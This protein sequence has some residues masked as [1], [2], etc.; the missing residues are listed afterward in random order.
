MD[1]EVEA[2]ASVV[3]A[4]SPVAPPAP[5]PV[6]P[7]QMVAR[8]LSAH[9]DWK[10]RLAAAIETGACETSVEHAA[11][12][13]RC[14]FGQWLHHDVP[15]RL[16]KTWDYATV[17]KRHA[18]LH[19]QVAQVLDLALLGRQAAANDA[20]MGGSPFNLAY[21]QFEASLREWYSRVDNQATGSAY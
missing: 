4:P 3:S 21:D 15:F 11:A 9:A 17:K 13:D 2:P 5:T 12:D 8:A 14:L 19:V 7:Q 16:R 1:I 20:M 10:V 18:E 6:P